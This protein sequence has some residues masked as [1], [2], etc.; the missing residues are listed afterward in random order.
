[1]IYLVGGCA[2]ACRCRGGCWWVWVILSIYGWVLM[3]QTD[4][5]EDGCIV[6]ALLF[7]GAGG[8]KIL[9]LKHKGGWE[10]K[11]NFS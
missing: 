2:Y 9:A 6:C 7:K 3:G 10:S 8:W 5:A 4:E 11:V 1:M